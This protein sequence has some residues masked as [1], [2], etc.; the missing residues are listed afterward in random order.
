MF[1]YHYL[2]VPTSRDGPL[3]KGRPRVLGAGAHAQ[4][5]ARRRGK[6][7]H[8]PEYSGQTLR[9]FITYMIMHL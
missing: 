3:L 4:S 1:G 6:G 2:P 5:L 7:S 8:S 9:Q